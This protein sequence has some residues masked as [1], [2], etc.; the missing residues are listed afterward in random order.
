MIIYIIPVMNVARKELKALIPQRLHI[1][2]TQ[3]RLLDSVGHGIDVFKVSVLLYNSLTG[4]FG[5]VYKA[6]LIAWHG[7]GDPRT[8]A[9]KTLRG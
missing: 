5:E 2:S 6:H 1:P 8:V 9:V 4:E 3:L 7:R